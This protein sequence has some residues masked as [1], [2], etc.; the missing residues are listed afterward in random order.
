MQITSSTMALY[1]VLAKFD[2][3]D[4]KIG[5]DKIPRA[6][7]PTAA[8]PALRI[9]KV[10]MNADKKAKTR[11]FGSFGR[12]GG[13]RSVN[14][15][16]RSRRRNGQRPFSHSQQIDRSD[17]VVTRRLLIPRICGRGIKRPSARDLRT[18]MASARPTTAPGRG[19]A[20]LIV[21]STFCGWQ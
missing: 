15:S 19:K 10:K 21:S 16:R 7:L 9:N 20:T 1:R 2:A 5:R 18:L 4:A 12:T 3:L 14:E 11:S 17:T 13:R 8:R 6:R